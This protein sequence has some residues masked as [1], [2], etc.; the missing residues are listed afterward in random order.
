MMGKPMA[1]SSQFEYVWNG[2]TWRFS[3]AENLALFMA[4]PE[5]YAPQ[6]GGYCAQA[7]SEGN[8]ATTNPNAWRI[9]DGKLYLNYSLVVQQQWLQDIPGNI[10]RADANWPDV[11]ANGI[12][13][14]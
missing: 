5:A 7:V 13:H 14:Q 11:L 10:A 9:V 12:V 2:A 4:N 8:L 1:G 3:S 6:Y